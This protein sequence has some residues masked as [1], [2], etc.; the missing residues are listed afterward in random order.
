M[1][2]KCVKGIRLHKGR[3]HVGNQTTCSGCMKGAATKQG[4]LSAILCYPA[5]QKAASLV[6]L[7]A[8]APCNFDSGSEGTVAK[9]APLSAITCCLYHPSSAMQK[10][11]GFVLSEMRRHTACA[12]V[13][14]PVLPHIIPAQSRLP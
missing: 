7:R 2:G 5:Q 4:P 12:T 14:G 3:L 9:R 8:P 10:Q 13:S 1:K 6:A 11:R